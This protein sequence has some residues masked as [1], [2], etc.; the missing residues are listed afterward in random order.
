MLALL[1]TAAA[2]AA[3]FTDA[4]RFERW[5]CTSRTSFSPAVVPAHDTL[6]VPGI[7]DG[8]Q[9]AFAAALRR[10]SLLP[11]ADARA[12]RA[13]RARGA[14]PPTAGPS[15][16]TLR[17]S[18]ALAHGCAD[19]VA[20]PAPRPRSDFAVPA[21]GAALSDWYRA[22]CAPASSAAW[23][24]GYDPAYMPQQVVLTAG[25]VCIVACGLHG[26]E[27]SATALAALPADAAAA[28]CS[29][30]RGTRGRSR[31]SPT[32]AARGARGDRGADERRGVDASERAAPLGKVASTECDYC[33]LQYEC[34]VEL[35]ACVRVRGAGT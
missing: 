32:R 18:D 17:A 33:D 5:S 19:V 29:R 14:T 8:K 9:A 3:A 11:A 28:T 31:A 6:D 22:L 1:G 20:P 2:A 24:G 12:A 30:W 25:Y 10:R 34:C 35:R 4:E 23:S 13:R 21:L 16:F 15:R 27:A 7:A 26:K